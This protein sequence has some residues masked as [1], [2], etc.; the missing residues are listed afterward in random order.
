MT[1]DE[2]VVQQEATSEGDALPEPKE[3]QTQPSIEEQIAKAMEG[4]LENLSRTVQSHTDKAISRIQREADN[5]ARI[6]EDAMAA[7]DATGEETDVAKPKPRVQGQYRSQLEVR[8]QQEAA[9]KQT[10]DAFESNIRQHIVDL[11]IDPDDKGIEWGDSNNLSLTDRQGKILASVSKIQKDNAKLADE[12]RKQE[13]D[14]LE[15]KLRK[16]LGLDTVDTTTSAGVISESD[17]DFMAKFGSGELPM[18]KAN[19]DRYNKIKDKYY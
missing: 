12:K 3:A 9:V 15:A 5:T 14:A 8:R 18:T 1:Q 4:Q 13:F 19:T 6:T 7:L 11:G 17:S 10:V 16:D 2:K